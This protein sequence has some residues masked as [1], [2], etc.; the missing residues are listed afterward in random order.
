MGTAFCKGR[1][2]EGYL[3]QLEPGHTGPCS[4]VRWMYGGQHRRIFWWPGATSGEYIGTTI[5]PEVRNEND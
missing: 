1:S 5:K 2:S 3:C 4:R